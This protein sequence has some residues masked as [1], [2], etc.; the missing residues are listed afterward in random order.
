M[1]TDDETFADVV[2]IL[3]MAAKREVQYEEDG[4]LKKELR[5][6]NKSLYYETRIVNTSHLGE[7]I[8]AY[9]RLEQKAMEAENYTTP[10]RARVIKDWI[11]ARVDQYRYGLDGKSSES[12]RD[13]K[14]NQDTLMHLLRKQTTKREFVAD[15]EKARKLLSGFLGNREPEEA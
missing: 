4:I 5:T 9:E 10:K 1:A 3:G 14:N 8:I 15:N 12:Q 7:A 2:D 13:G 11:L 6:D